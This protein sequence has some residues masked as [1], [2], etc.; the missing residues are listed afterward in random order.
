M[1]KGILEKISKNFGT[2]QTAKDFNL[3]VE[4][5]PVQEEKYDEKKI[6]IFIPH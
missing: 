2:V 5:M 3:R 1:A 6:K 4:E